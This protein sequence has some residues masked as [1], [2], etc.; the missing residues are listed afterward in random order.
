[1]TKLSLYTFRCIGKNQQGKAI[2]PRTIHKVRRGGFFI[3]D[4]PDYDP[5]IEISKKV[6]VNEVF[7]GW[8]CRNCKNLIACQ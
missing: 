5:R 3:P 2:I 1:M 8:N 4:C 6:K 7:T